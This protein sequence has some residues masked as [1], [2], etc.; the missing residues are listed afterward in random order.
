MTAPPG[1]EVR[2]PH[3]GRFYSCCFVG[4]RRSNK[5]KEP[6][7]IDATQ[8]ASARGES[9]GRNG[10]THEDNSLETVAIKE[11][12]DLDCYLAAVVEP[13]TQL[14]GAEF[15]VCRRGR[16]RRKQMRDLSHRGAEEEMVGRHFVQ[17]PHAGELLAEKP[18]LLLRN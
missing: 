9:V 16:K 4:V 5:L 8:V 1:F 2:T 14:R 3:R 12:Q 17:A 6:L 11:F 15:A 18:H 13:V 7:R 10:F